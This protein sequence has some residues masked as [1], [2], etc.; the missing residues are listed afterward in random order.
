MVARRV[1]VGRRGQSITPWVIV[2]NTQS[3]QDASDR[4]LS[5][6]T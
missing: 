6:S 4:M 1:R 3:R 5:R 2:N